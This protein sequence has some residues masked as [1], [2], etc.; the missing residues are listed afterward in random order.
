MKQG[1]KPVVQIHFTPTLDAC[2]SRVECTFWSG[3][4]RKPIFGKNR[5]RSEHRHL[6]LIALVRRPAV[7][8]YIHATIF[9][10]FP[11]IPFLS[12]SFWEALRDPPSIWFEEELYESDSDST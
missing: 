10:L 12:G 7:P 8:K 6:K 2:A 1:I 11:L 9:I 5:V 3:L 4:E